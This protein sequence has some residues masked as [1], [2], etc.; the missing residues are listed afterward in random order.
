MVTNLTNQGHLKADLKVD[1]FADEEMNEFEDVEP[2]FE[3]NDYE[4]LAENLG[5]DLIRSTR[6]LRPRLT[7]E[8]EK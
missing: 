5:N 7:R 1:E 4:R 2:D 3:M 8:H 6:A